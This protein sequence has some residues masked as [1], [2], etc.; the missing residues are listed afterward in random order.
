MR[1]AARRGRAPTTPIGLGRPGNAAGWGTSTLA[2]TRKSP[3][4]WLCSESELE[5]RICGVSAHPRA[6]FVNTRTADAP[7]QL[8]S[9]HMI[10]PRMNLLMTS[11]FEGTVMI[12]ASPS[13]ST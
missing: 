10:A 8:I 3:L 13:S 9:T 5:L 1:P 6:Y 7:P 12:S 11:P 4:E 2:G